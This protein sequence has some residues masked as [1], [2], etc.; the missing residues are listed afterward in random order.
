[1]NKLLLLLSILLVITSALAGQSKQ[2]YIRGLVID[3]GS[4]YPVPYARITWDT[5]REG[6]LT[7]ADGSFSIQGFESGDTSRLLYIKA[8]GYDTYRLLVHNDSGS[9]P[10]L[11]KLSQIS[12]TPVL[13]QASKISKR[14]V[15]TPS[16]ERLRNTPVAS[17]QAD[18]MK[19]LTIY[20]GISGGREGLTALHVRGGNDDQN[21]Y[22]LDGTTIYNPGH[23]FG[24]LSVFNPN[25]VANVDIYK[26]FIPARLARRLSSVIEVSTRDG[27]AG[28]RLR[29]REIGLLG[30]SYTDEGPTKDSSITYAAG[31]RL[32]HTALLTL[33]TLPGYLAKND[34]PLLFAGMYDFNFKM[35]K[36]IS[37]SRKL[38]GSIYLGDDL[39]GGTIRQGDAIETSAESSSLLRYGNRS[40]S[41]LYTNKPSVGK[42][43]NTRLNI[44]AFNNSYRL[45][46]ILGS[47]EFTKETLYKNGASLKEIAFHHD[48]YYSGA[49]QSLTM[50]MTLAHLRVEPTRIKIQED[51][52]FRELPR[53]LRTTTEAAFYTD[54]LVDIGQK[55][56][57][58]AGLRIAGVY[59]RSESAV[60]PVYS[61][62]ASVDRQLGDGF[63]SFG[64]RRTRQL[65]HSIDL[66]SGGLPVRVWLPISRTLPPETDETLS[67]TYDRNG[68]N[69]R[70]I[71]M[72]LY[73]RNF[74]NQVLQPE[75]NLSF[76]DANRWEESII[77]NGTG[78]SY[79][80]EFY[81]EQPITGRVLTS[82][83]YTYSRS[84]RQF[85]E[86]NN[87]EEFSYDY[88]RPHD[89][90][91]S[92]NLSLN[93][94]W[95]A[96]GAFSLASGLPYSQ[97]TANALDPTGFISPVI[98][99]YN[100]GRYSTY[101]RMDILFIR[102]RKTRGG[103]EGLLKFGIYNMYGRR[104]PLFFSYGLKGSGNLD[105]VT[106]ER[107]V[108]FRDDFRFGTLFT[109]FPMLSYEVRY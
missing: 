79:G 7:D 87:G 99:D 15:L 55:W 14:G 43:H 77:P 49:N 58:R 28:E 3:S 83:S 84:F 86:F 13:V 26:D 45:R 107:K 33:G 71:I 78:K 90:Y 81:F 67:L 60:E 74:R 106:G 46:E 93:E 102:E 56:N 23:L 63:F 18:I 70:Q 97:P 31:V 62:L 40:A 21:L 24:F 51:E 73:Y 5:L 76:T 96:V 109:F 65:I 57:L 100:N 53:T 10:F 19:G 69:D 37:S 16:I 66:A 61:Y 54:A 47:G 75:R 59:L 34:I 12:F 44:G 104:N 68:E 29:S 25:T 89:L 105:P 32:A 27:S 108:T 72:S 22:L 4:G 35:V 95:S 1:M 82:L 2:P 50:G 39:Y 48:R 9:L 101:H 52:S 38:T 42:R 17:G 85:D 8:L 11:I 94:K 80:F 20:P 64:Y 98:Q 92:I 103:K 36:T 88:D 6:S 30:L 41:F 91:V